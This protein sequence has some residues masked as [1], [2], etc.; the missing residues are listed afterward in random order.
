MSTSKQRMTDMVTIEIP[1]GPFAT[2]IKFGGPE[3]IVMEEL[4]Q[5]EPHNGIMSRTTTTRRYFNDSYIDSVVVATI[6]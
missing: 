6:A 1:S 4:V 3:N 2:A 5:Y